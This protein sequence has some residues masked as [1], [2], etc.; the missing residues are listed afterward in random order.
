MVHPRT[1]HAQVLKNRDLINNSLRAYAALPA[2][3]AFIQH[4]LTRANVHTI[5]QSTLNGDDV[6]ATGAGAGNNRRSAGIAAGQAS[7]KVVPG[8]RGSVV[9]VVPSS[10]AAGRRRAVSG[11][12]SA[13]NTANT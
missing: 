9:A 13:I 4:F 1:F 10:P 8:R 5:G 12:P 11:V 7:S 2:T 6:S 3:K